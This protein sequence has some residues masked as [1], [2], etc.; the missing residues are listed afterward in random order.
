[1]KKLY[2]FLIVFISSV[3]FN[4]LQAANMQS[5]NMGPGV[6]KG[7]PDFGDGVK[8]VPLSKMA[9]TNEMKQKTLRSMQMQKTKGFVDSDSD[10]PKQLLRMGRGEVV[11]DAVNADPHDTHLKKNLSQIKLAFSFKGIPSMEG[12]D[13]IGY[14]VMGMWNNGWSGISEFF[15]KAPIGTCKF[16]LSS[17]SV[18]QGA[19][20]ISE[21]VARYDVNKK[22]TTITIKGNKEKGFLYEISWADKAYGYVLECASDK[23][24]PETTKEAVK[25]AIAI[26]KHTNN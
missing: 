20:W 9:I 8:V 10:W 12:S 24:D 26:D 25:L 18:A 17:F 22:P 23:L 14:A 16:S 6:P 21:E 5:G 11:V 13:I 4:P 3:I 2:F 15:N 19:W 7:F 1:M